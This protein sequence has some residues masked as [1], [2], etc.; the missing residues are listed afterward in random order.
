MNIKTKSKNVVFFCDNK[1]IITNYINDEIELEEK[2]CL[3]KEFTCL[4]GKDSQSKASDFFEMIKQNKMVVGYEMFIKTSDEEKM[5]VFSGI[6]LNDNI[7]II[8]SDTYHAFDNLFDEMSKISNEQT[9][10]IRELAQQKAKIA[11]LERK[12][13]ERDLHDSVSQTI[14]ST[15][16]IAE[17]LPDLWKKNQKEAQKQLEKL[18]FLTKES[19]KEMR[20]LLVELR[21]ESFEE[22][23]LDYLLSQLVDSVKLR[24]NVNI[25]LIVKGTGNP[26]KEVKE[27]FY[28]ITQEAL[29]NIIKH[30]GADKVKIELKYLS[31]KIYLEIE[32]NGGGFQV[33][34]ISKK[35]FGLFIMQERAKSINSSLKIS[36]KKNKGTKITVTY[37]G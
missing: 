5:L 1:G 22:E 14:F 26:K 25:Q 23:R 10:I 28:R 8:A 16:V 2:Q 13:I 27:N 3:G 37:R 15:I 19:L 18:K 35:N 31:D 6:D 33:D 36:S 17:I 4:L 7:L 20:R 11:Q 29:N 12:R 34:K 9:N 21:P 24:S 30:S 32:D